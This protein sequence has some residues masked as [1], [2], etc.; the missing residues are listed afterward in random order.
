MTCAD[1]E[2]LICDYATLA[3]HERFA[4]ERHLA[5][6]AACAE[7]AR[8]CAEA[9]EFIGR[10]AEV[11]PPPELITRIL[12]DAPWAKGRSKARARGALWVRL[13]AIFSPLL[14]PR[15]VMGA[16]M[17]ILSISMLARPV[18]QIRLDDLEPARVWAGME[19]RAVRVW[20][21]T[22]KFYD[23]LKIVYDIQNTLRQWQQQDEE[24]R[25]PAAAPG[26]GADEHRLPVNRG[27]GSGGV[28]ADSAGRDQGKD[29]R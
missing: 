29:A 27:Q 8:D 26:T 17:T 21:R 14:A 19:D 13:A 2:I 23:N 5:E 4:L 9:V 18:R 11:D 25:P 24:L 12:F 1:A 10:T 28:P 7:L 22:V 15:F 6:C 20:A 3:S 16:A